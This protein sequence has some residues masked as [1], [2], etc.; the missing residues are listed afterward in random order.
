M[1]LLLGI[2]IISYYYVG[3]IVNVMSDHSYEVSLVIMSGQS[4][5]ANKA[6]S[7]VCK[8]IPN[9]FNEGLLLNNQAR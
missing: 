4:I 7:D 5:K 2:S 8:Q 9:M 6:D 3:L 1:D